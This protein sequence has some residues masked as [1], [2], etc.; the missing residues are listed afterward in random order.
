MNALLL[1]ASLK[2]AGHRIRCWRD[3]ETMDVDPYL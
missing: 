3:H 2:E 1:A